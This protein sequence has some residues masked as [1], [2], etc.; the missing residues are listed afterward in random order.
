MLW[1][2][3]PTSSP[4]AA[5]VKI[6]TELKAASP[7]A[8]SPRRLLQIL[9]HRTSKLALIAVLLCP[10]PCIIGQDA[11]R[12]IPATRTSP[13]VDWKY[14]FGP[15]PLTGYRQVAPNTPYAAETGYGFDLG[16]DIV[17][18]ERSANDPVAAGYATGKEGKPFFFS[19]SV[20]EGNYKVTVTLGDAAAASETTVRAELRRLMVERLR[21]EPGQFQTRSFIVNVR[22]PAIASGGQVRINAREQSTEARAWDDLLAL[23]FAGPHAALV[24]LQIEKV[25][26]PTL[27]L[28]GDST[29][30]DQPV[31]PYNSWGQMITRFFR[32]NIAVANHAESG[33]SV[34][35]ALSARRFDKIWS[36]IRPGDYLFVQFGHNDMKSSAPNALETFTSNLR[37]IVAE[38]RQRSGVPVLFTP[39]SRRTFDSSGKITNSFR[40]YPDA[41]KL[42][43]SDMNVPLIDLQRSSAKFY[44]AMGVEA[45]HQAFAN[46]SEGTHHGDYG[47]YQIAKSIVQLIKEVKLPI[48]EHLVDDWKPFD[49][50]HPDPIREFSQ[51][52][53]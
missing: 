9:A 5:N 27:W 6:R 25:D 26:L 20:P 37:R 43:A 42:V 3:R 33:E 40:G 51:S 2:A 18:V 16:S 32:P 23:E 11:I 35:G 50:S 12:A 4:V 13:S 36:E 15:K 49:P 47:S 29:V 24:S 45:S 30:C 41:I 48:T 8:F 46:E 52:Y 31:E 17:M 22:Q 39:V 10:V 21:T 1:H 7:P 34:A 38:T 53:R 14:S 44:E 28:I 19:V